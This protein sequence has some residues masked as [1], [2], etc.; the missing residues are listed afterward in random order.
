MPLLPSNAQADHFEFAE[1]GKPECSWGELTSYAISIGFDQGAH[2][3]DPSGDGLGQEERVGLA[4][5]VEQGN[6]E[7]TCELIWDL[8]I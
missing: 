8:L 2:A 7:A 5:V 3:S 6:L 1:L 4:N